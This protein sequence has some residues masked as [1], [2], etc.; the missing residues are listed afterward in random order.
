MMIGKRETS[1]SVTD[2]QDFHT[3]SDSIKRLAIS[4]DGHPS[5]SYSPEVDEGLHKSPRVIPT[6]VNM[7]INTAA[8]NADVIVQDRGKPIPISKARVETTG[9]PIKSILSNAR[10]DFA[11]KY[12]LM[13]EIGRGGFS[14]VYQC[15][16]RLSGI[17]HAVKVQLIINAP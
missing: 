17:V 12:E 13:S 3:V 8:V 6:T 4:I 15:R 2:L 7:N 1:M 10:T 14:T 11:E 9:L 16:D 5:K